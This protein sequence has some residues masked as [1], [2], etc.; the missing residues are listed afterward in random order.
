MVRDAVLFLACVLVPCAVGLGVEEP[1][2]WRWVHGLGAVLFLIATLMVF[3]GLRLLFA[4]SKAPTPKRGRPRTETH[5]EIL[6]PDLLLGGGP[7]DAPIRPVSAR[8]SS[9]II[10]V[11]RSPGAARVVALLRTGDLPD[12]VHLLELDVIGDD[13]RPEVIAE[14]VADVASGEPTEELTPVDRVGY[15]SGW[16]LTLPCP[17]LTH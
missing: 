6:S 1:L 4:P 2:R 12:D 15:A 11:A 5:P 8:A 3:T 13:L 7:L 14:A 10:H 9:E 17:P 16:G